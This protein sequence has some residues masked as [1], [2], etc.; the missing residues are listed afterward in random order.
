MLRVAGKLM[1]IVALVLL[2]AAVLMQLTAGI[3]APTGEG[4][5]VS[6]MLLMLILGVSLFGVGRIIEGYGSAP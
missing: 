6:A 5:T 2:P 3:R 1:Q 4:I